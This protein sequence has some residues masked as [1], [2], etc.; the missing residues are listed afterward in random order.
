M[1]DGDIFAPLYSASPTTPV[2]GLSTE[3]MAT[4]PYSPVHGGQDDT[5][6]RVIT[7]FFFPVDIASGFRG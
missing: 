4:S 3:K 1:D 6:N 7:F 2:V 5:N